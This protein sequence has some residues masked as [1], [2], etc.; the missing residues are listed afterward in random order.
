MN[1]E[2]YYINKKRVAIFIRFLEQ[3]EC[4]CEYDI[5]EEYFTRGNKL[6]KKL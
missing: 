2:Y 5:Q 6:Y 4:G 3:G 1:A